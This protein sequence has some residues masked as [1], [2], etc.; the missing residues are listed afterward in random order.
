MQLMSQPLVYPA[1]SDSSLGQR[2]DLRRRERRVL[3][4]SQSH[5]LQ[6]PRRHTDLLTPPINLLTRSLGEIWSF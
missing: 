5:P 6:Q 1:G 2:L 3:E 4:A